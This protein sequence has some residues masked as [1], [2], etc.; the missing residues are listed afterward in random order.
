MELALSLEASTSQLETEHQH[1]AELKAE[2][3]CYRERFGD[4]E[5]ESGANQ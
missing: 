2:L 1:R 4:L 5:G 3:A